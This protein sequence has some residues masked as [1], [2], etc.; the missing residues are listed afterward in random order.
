MGLKWK[1][2]TAKQL[3][4]AF[5]GASAGGKAAAFA[6]L[7]AETNIMKD[8]SVAQSPVDEGNLEEAHKVV[9]RANGSDKRTL[10]IVVGGTVNG[11]D[12]DQYA[13]V[14]HESDYKLGPKSRLKQAQSPYI[15]GP[16]FLERAFTGRIETALANIYDAL[17]GKVRTYVG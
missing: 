13:T 11:V 3:A 2:V 8:I 17:V 6:T 1:T 5:Q 4:D 10:D 14:M 9:T 12:V 7:A 15:V 16:K